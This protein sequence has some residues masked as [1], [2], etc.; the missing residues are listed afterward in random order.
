[1]NGWTLLV[2]FVAAGIGGVRYGML[3]AR[4]QREVRRNAELTIALATALSGKVD[5]DGVA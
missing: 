2:V 5:D 3:E 4:Y 1:V